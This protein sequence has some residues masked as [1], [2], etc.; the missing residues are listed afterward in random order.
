MTKISVTITQT[1]MSAMRRIG[2]TGGMATVSLLH[3]HLLTWLT[4]SDLK[5][6]L[7]HQAVMDGL[8]SKEKSAIRTGQ[9]AQD[10]SKDI[11]V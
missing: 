2:A 5:P 3:L 9:K 7:S 4:Q 11:T 8:R 6:R 10:I 1:G